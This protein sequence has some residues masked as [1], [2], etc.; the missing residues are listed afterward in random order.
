MRKQALKRLGLSRET[1]LSLSSEQARDVVGANPTDASACKMAGSC[2]AE[3]C[4]FTYL[5]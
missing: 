5:C 4:G 1:L 3:G 2:P